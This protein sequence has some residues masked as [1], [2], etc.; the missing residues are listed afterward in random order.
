MENEYI[1]LTVAELENEQVCC[2]VRKKPHPGI[3]AKRAWLS[4]RLPEGHVFR[5]LKAA[6][7]AFIEYAPLESAFV[8][9]LGENYLYI[10]CLWVQGAPK[11]KGYGK[12]LMEYCI[13]D[14]RARGCSGVCMLG[15][16][17]QKAWLSDQS[18]AAK[19]GFFVADTAG[20]YELLALSFDGSLPHFTPSAKKG[21]V[22][23]GGLTVFYSDQCPFIPQ[24]VEKL[25]EYCKAH[26]IPAE[27]CHV[28]SREKAK[29]LPCPF[30]NWAVFYGGRFVTVNQIDGAALQK[31][32]EREKRP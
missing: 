31:I 23:G 3:A 6:D 27:F 26:E 32:I 29:A 11:G 24:R 4:E 7:C 13:A 30:N 14:A 9:A 17:S 16:K 22:T 1:N 25:R 10:Y 8:P 15:A 21:T 5:K 2:V 28:D 19:F 20:E 18:F 12:A